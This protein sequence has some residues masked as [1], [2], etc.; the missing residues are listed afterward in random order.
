MS[1]GSGLIGTRVG[2]YDVLRRL[3][4]GGMGAVYEG[5]QP[6][7]G[8]RVAIKVLH[9]HLAEQPD[10]L[11]RFEIEARSVNRIGH[12]GIIDI[13][14]FG[15]LDDGSSYF[16]MELLEGRS[17]EQVLNEDGAL[18][19]SR[20]L[21]YFA[22]ILDAVGAAHEADVIHRDLK[23]S[24]LFL[25]ENTRGRGRAFVKVLDFGIAKLQSQPDLTRTRGGMMGTPQYMAP[26]QVL[27]QPIGPRTDIYALG[28]VL[29]ELLTGKKPF[30]AADSLVM[31][32][33]QVQ[34]VPPLV[35]SL[36][37]TTPAEVDSLVAQMLEKLPEKR[38][39]SCDALYEQV[40]VLLAK[41]GTDTLP[42]AR[43]ADEVT[44]LERPSGKRSRAPGSA[45]G[46]V[47]DANRTRGA[48]G[49]TTR[50][51]GVRH[52]VATPAPVAAP[53]A[54]P[55]ADPAPA[56]TLVMAE[57]PRLTSPSLQLEAPPRSPLPYVVVA[58]GLLLGV[59]LALYVSSTPERVRPPSATPIAGAVP[60]PPLR[61]PEPEPRRPA[62][63]SEAA[64]TPPAVA[65]PEPDPEAERAGAGE[66]EP[67]QPVE[68]KGPSPLAQSRRAAEK[69]LAGTERQL[70]AKEKLA[71]DKDPILRRFLEQC[72]AQLK[73]ARSAADYARVGQSLDE[74]DAQIRAN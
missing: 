30:G 35:S 71:G 14:S 31:M 34:E 40:L 17:F 33:K 65:S 46:S 70:A 27:G 57:R 62:P 73:A 67:R 69:H 48:P 19:L 21:R 41:Y 7:I 37:A 49:A 4:V 58:L 16:V 44:E 74:L 52:N 15:Q 28:L 26:E 43:N 72:R 56:P 36:A 3:G 68:G 5:L 39:A 54:A 9:P 12:R 45:S 61:E 59:T 66:P 47:V 8:K 13:F 32:R 55:A 10:V 29:F 60:A 38:P 20:A 51:E 64:T 22:E 53:A 6:V 1:G 25:V 18:G 50:I 2:E 42:P 24:N 63:Q 23:T 11:Q